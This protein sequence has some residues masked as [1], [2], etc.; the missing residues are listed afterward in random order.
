M[1]EIHEYLRLCKEDSEMQNKERVT[2]VVFNVIEEINQ[3]LPD[4]QQLEKSRET[5]L[6]GRLSELDSLGLVN[7]IIATEQ[8]IEEEF[9]VTITIADERAMSQK[10]SPFKTLGALIDYAC[11]LL[12]KENDE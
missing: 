4:N 3:E 12:E 2:K 9:G 6:F 11:L 8:A 1:G 5:V 10:N 7:L